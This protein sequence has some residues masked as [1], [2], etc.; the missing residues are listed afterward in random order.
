VAL[1]FYWRLVQC[2]VNECELWN[3]IGLCSFFAAQYDMALNC[4]QRAITL[5]DDTSLCDV[6][7]NVGHVAISIGDL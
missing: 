3:N 7:Y 5:A 6:Y 1:R 2:G 4:F